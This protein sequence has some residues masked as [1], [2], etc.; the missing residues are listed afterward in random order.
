[1]YVKHLNRRLFFY[2]K[3]AIDNS[4]S[5]A[6]FRTISVQLVKSTPNLLLKVPKA[7]SKFVASSWNFVFLALADDTRLAIIRALRKFVATY[8]I[9]KKF[10]IIKEIEKKYNHHK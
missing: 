2:F 6:C 1:M 8:R 3:P 4:L 9:C 10:I 5:L 7:V